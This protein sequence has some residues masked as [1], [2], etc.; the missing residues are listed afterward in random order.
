MSSA[1]LLIPV[2][3]NPSSSAKGTKLAPENELL[4]I[5]I[6]FSD[7]SELIEERDYLNTVACIHFRLWKRSSFLSRPCLFFSHNS[8]IAFST[9]FFGVNPVAK[10]LSELTL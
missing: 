1:G 9:D 10:S 7:M 6:I 3:S 4:P 2:T 8:K 5:M